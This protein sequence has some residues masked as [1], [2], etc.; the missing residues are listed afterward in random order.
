MVP[1]QTQ[2]MATC[3]AWRGMGCVGLYLTLESPWDENQQPCRTGLVTTQVSKDCVLHHR[4]GQRCQ[5]CYWCIIKDSWKRQ[6]H[7]WHMEYKDSRSRRETLGTHKMNRYGWNIL[8]LCEMRWK[9]GETTTENQ[10][11]CKLFFSGKEDKHKHGFGFLV[12]KD[13]VSTVM[14]CCPLSSRLITI[15]LRAVPFNITVV[16]AYAPMSD[17]EVWWQWNRRTL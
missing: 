13:I 14:G 16:Q 11:G 3:S 2:S 12:H 9:L 5:E 8:W 10:E 4:P 1:W 6:H 15:R 7:H 17:Y